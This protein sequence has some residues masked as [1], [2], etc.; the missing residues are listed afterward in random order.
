MKATNNFT[1]STG[2]ERKVGEIYINRKPGSYFLH[3]YEEL[4]ETLKA[5]VLTDKKSI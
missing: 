1:D 3:P 4:I 5:H 2:V